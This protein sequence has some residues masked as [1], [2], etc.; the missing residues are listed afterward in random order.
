MIMKTIL[1]L[2]LIAVAL[3]LTG[4]RSHRTI[5][6]SRKESVSTIAGISH[7]VK[8]H[9]DRQVLLAS[10][11]ETQLA[12]DSIV[13]R[14]WER[15][16]TD[17]CGHVLLHEMERSKDR[18]RN[19]TRSTSNR[20]DSTRMETETDMDEVK[21]QQADSVYNGSRSVNERKTEDR[22]RTVRFLWIIPVLLVLGILYLKRK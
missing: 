2:L 13:E 17:S 4:C 6:D 8:Q 22:F 10:L 18:Y 1:K 21:L 14:V 5:T 11:N 9:I 7:G 20:T 12:S 16:V 15:I 19:R 3:S